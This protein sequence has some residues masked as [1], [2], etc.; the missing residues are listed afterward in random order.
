MTS[1][2]SLAAFV[3]ALASCQT[4]PKVFV[5]V[6]PNIHRITEHTHL[7]HGALEYNSPP[8]VIRARYPTTVMRGHWGEKNPNWLR[9]HHI[10]LRVQRRDCSEIAKQFRALKGACGD[11]LQLGSLC[12]VSVYG[13]FQRHHFPWGEAISFI[14]QGTQDG[15][16]SPDNGHMSFQIWGVSNDMR[17]LVTLSVGITR[18]DWPDWTD[19]RLRSYSHMHELASDPD[20]R[21]MNSD[22]ATSFTPCLNSIVELASSVV[23]EGNP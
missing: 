7:R 13:R 12:S 3:I 9:Q 16:Y 18:P 1:K 20:V 10:Y 15:P 17:H 21:R 11:Y 19:E 23:I 22:S 14:H 5:A 2:A 8:Y 4:S 6:D